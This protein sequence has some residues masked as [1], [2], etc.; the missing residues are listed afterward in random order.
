MFLV[1]DNREYRSQR[2]RSLIDIDIEIAVLVAA[3]DFE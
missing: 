2:I 3:A 1:S